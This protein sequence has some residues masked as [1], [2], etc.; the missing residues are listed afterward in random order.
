MKE[1]LKRSIRR[2]HRVPVLGQALRMLAALY[3][4]PDFRVAQIVDSQVT[5]AA[6]QQLSEGLAEIQAKLDELAALPPALRE[7]EAPRTNSDGR[8]LATRTEEER[9]VLVDERESIAMSLR[10][11]TRA[12]AEFSRVQR[13]RARDLL[14][15][16][17]QIAGVKQRLAA[18]TSGGN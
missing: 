15:V 17:S 5:A 14:E 9:L 8:A 13:T 7:S 11:L 6:L 18:L 10:K 2:L 1:L 16:E 4:L 3:R 12:Q